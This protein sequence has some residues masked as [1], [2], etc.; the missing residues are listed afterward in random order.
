MIVRTA[1][2]VPPDNNV[3]RFGL[4]VRVGLEP[5]LGDIDMVKLTVPPKPPILAKVMVLLLAEPLVT[6]IRDGLAIIEKSGEGV[7]TT[8]RILVEL[9]LSFPLV[10]SMPIVEVL[11]GVDG[12][13]ETVSVEAPA[14]VRRDT[15]LGFSA[16]VTFVIPGE[17]E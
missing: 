7:G 15:E 14:P 16:I 13:T 10:P 4:R 5:L 9:W 17:S 6:F 3:T 11:S 8:L 1:F 12:G 2:P